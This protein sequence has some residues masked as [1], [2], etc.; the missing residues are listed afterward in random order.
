MATCMDTE[1]QE[2]LY[3]KLDGYTRL[4]VRIGRLLE[5]EREDV[6]QEAMLWIL[7]RHAAC[8]EYNEGLEK[9]CERQDEMLPEEERKEY[10]PDLRNAIWTARI[11]CG[12][13]RRESK[14]RRLCQ[15]FEFPIGGLDDF[16]AAEE[17]AE[18]S[19]E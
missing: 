18:E 10:T 3:H 4:L 13:A 14:T 1:K 15:P 9:E 7:E 16:A 8:H 12:F 11:N 5:Q 19:E 6:M 2:E 17:S